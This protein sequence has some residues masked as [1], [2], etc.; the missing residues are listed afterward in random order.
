MAKYGGEYLTHVYRGWQDK[1]FLYQSKGYRMYDLNQQAEFY[2]VIA[3]L[4]YY[5]LSGHIHVGFLRNFRGNPYVCFNIF[6]T[7]LEICSKLSL[8]RPITWM[9]L[10]FP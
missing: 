1:I 7:L 8:S 6:H 4:F 10:F 3:K 2:T 9:T 5:V